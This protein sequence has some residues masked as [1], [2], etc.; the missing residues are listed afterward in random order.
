M[1]SFVS[2]SF[3]CL[4]SFFQLFFSSNHPT[5]VLSFFILLS[6]LTLQNSC[7]K[8]MNPCYPSPA[9]RDLLRISAVPARVEPAQ[10]SANSSLAG[11]WESCV[12]IRTI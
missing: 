6:Y 4:L 2:F 7:H 10:L 1:H 11:S 12:W 8:L 5:I 3:S 9:M